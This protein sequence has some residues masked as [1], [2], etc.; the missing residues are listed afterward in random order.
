MAV[1]AKGQEDARK[2]REVGAWSTPERAAL[3]QRVR[4]IAHATSDDLLEYARVELDDALDNVDPIVGGSEFHAGCCMMR[5]ITAL[6]TV[7]DR[8]RADG[9]RASAIEEAARVCDDLA[10]IEARKSTDDFD[11]GRLVGYER[12]GKRETMPAMNAVAEVLR[13]K[14]DEEMARFNSVG[15]RA[16]RNHQDRT[17]VVDVD[18]ELPT[19]AEKIVLERPSSRPAVSYSDGS[20]LVCELT[21]I[22]A[23]AGD[24]FH[25]DSKPFP[26]AYGRK[27]V[28]LIDKEANIIGVAPIQDR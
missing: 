14:G 6:E 5:A 17:V 22:P 13:S 10:K 19:S 2:R 8:L 18:A 4:S 15:L 7:R 3:L 1:D 28:V 20:S 23:G 16:T 21:I 9:V 27:Y 24:R 11:T 12:A 26:H 25:S